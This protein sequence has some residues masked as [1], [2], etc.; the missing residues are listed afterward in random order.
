M[1]DIRDDLRE[2][3]AAVDAREAEAMEHYDERLRALHLERG[4]AL[5][6]LDRERSILHDL[7]V[8]EAHRAGETPE[9]AAEY[10]RR[11]QLRLPLPDFIFNKV[12]GSGPVDKE[13]LRADADHAGYEVNAR[14]FHATLLNMVKHGKLM[15]LDDG[16]YAAPNG[17]AETLFGLGQ[18]ST[19]VPMMQ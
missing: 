6:A 12:L 8:L 2:R 10:V 1:R 19:E 7:L 4:K 13:A 18:Q 9:G 14:S 17:S 11:A 16:R 15:Q 3:L 5:E